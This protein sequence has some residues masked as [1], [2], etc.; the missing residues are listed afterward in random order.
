MGER[1]VIIQVPSNNREDLLI[2]AGQL[3]VETADVLESH[4]FDGATMLTL[5]V[6]V[7]AST[8]AVLRTWLM[9]RAAARKSTKVTI[10]GKH[11]EGYTKDEVLAIM[12]AVRHSDDGE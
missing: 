12:E 8:A 5:L 3:E 11:F 10:D 6:S 4:A 2:L 9:T 7:S 1:T